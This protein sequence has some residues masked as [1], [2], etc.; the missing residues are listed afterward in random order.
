MRHSE[1]KDHKDAEGTGGASF[2]WGKAES[3]VLLSL[4]KEAQGALINV[5]KY[6]GGGC[7]EEGSRLLTV[8]PRDRMK[9][10]GHKLK[11]RRFHLNI[12]RH[13]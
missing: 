5:C 7:R 3:L 6:L 8:V 12:R 11:C 2:L 13:F 10:I 9:G 1:K 4:E